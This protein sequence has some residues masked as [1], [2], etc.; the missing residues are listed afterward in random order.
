MNRT[1]FFY[2]GTELWSYWEDAVHS[3]RGLPHVTD[4]R[5]MGMIGA[6][7]LESIPGHITKR[8]TEAF[9]KAYGKGL[10]IRTT[11]D[12]IAFSPP[13]IIEKPHIDFMFETM[14]DVL[15]SIE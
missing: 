11:G 4:I 6:V 15:K 3:L 9:L 5:N 14:H 10:L 13:L 2:K 1:A 7:E 12:I 8:A